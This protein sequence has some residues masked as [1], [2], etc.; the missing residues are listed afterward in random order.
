M[1]R[2]APGPPKSDTHAIVRH[3]VREWKGRRSKPSASDP[4][5]VPDVPRRTRYLGVEVVRPRTNPLRYRA[6][7]TVKSRRVEIGIYDG[8]EVAAMARDDYAMAQPDPPYRLNF[9]SRHPDFVPRKHS[10]AKF[11]HPVQVPCDGH[12]RHH[13]R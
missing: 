6:V 9:P 3:Y 8:P 2:H 5:P 12:L 4:P 10:H 7:L 13:P 11:A 1:T